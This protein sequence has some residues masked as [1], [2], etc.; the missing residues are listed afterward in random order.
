MTSDLSDLF[1]ILAIEIAA[2]DRAHPAGYPATRDGL[3]MGIASLEDELREVHDEW[4]Q[5]KKRDGWGG[6]EDELWQVAGIAMR[7]IRGLREGT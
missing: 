3:R 7:M 6:M 1:D 5:W 2:Q 4:H